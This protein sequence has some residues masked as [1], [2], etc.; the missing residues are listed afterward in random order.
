MI[1]VTEF[2]QEKLF[3]VIKVADKMKDIVNSSG[4]CD[5]M[6]GKIMA[7][8]FLEPSTRTQ[9]SFTAAMLRLGGQVIPL[10]AET[11]STK[12]GESLQVFIL[13]LLGYCPLPRVL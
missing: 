4:S 10:N 6:K 3:D 5:L 11:S 9:S 13:F 12:K 8:V 7:T 1:S 2:N